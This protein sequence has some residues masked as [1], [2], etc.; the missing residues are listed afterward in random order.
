VPVFPSASVTT[1]VSVY[2]DG[3]MLGISVV[4]PLVRFIVLDEPPFGVIVNTILVIEFCGVELYSR[5]ENDAV[6]VIFKYDPDGSVLPPLLAR[7]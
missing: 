3:E 6:G 1:S 2:V 5:L 4:V 7:V